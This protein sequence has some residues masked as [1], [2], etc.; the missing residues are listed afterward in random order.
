[1]T[2]TEQLTAFNTVYQAK[3]EEIANQY[4]NSLASLMVMIKHAKAY[5]PD[6]RT[7]EDALH[8]LAIRAARQATQ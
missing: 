7:R 2:A 4:G 8:V 6:V 3:R 1:M 5:S